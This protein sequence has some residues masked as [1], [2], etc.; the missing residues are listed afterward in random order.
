MTAFGLFV[1]A[2]CPAKSPN[3]IVSITLPVKVWEEVDC[4]S[5]GR[6]NIPTDGS[7]LVAK[8][9][10]VASKV[11]ADPHCTFI[12]LAQPAPKT[13]LRSAETVPTTTV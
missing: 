10:A 1:V 8:S 11:P 13:A 4:L 7:A 9:C 12:S 3:A 6:A 5:Q 2:S